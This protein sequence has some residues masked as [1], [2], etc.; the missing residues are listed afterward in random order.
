MLTK[1][2][3]QLETDALY[4]VFIEYCVFSVTSGEVQRT[5]TDTEAGKTEKGLCPEYIL[6]IFAKSLHSVR[7]F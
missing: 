3:F 1:C 5:H 4:R 6:N 2:Y 7:C